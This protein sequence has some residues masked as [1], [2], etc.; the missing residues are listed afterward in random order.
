M[1]E[2]SK[3]DLNSLA[4]VTIQ[5]AQSD[6]SVVASDVVW[7]AAAIG[8]VLGCGARRA[9]YMLSSGSL[10]PAGA[11]MVQGRWCASRRKLI[12]FIEAEPAEAQ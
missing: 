4:I 8:D 1:H 6:L 9:H 10:K 7:G 2:K 12:A 11:K 5:A 3:S